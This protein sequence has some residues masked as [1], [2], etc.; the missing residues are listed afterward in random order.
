MHQAVD[1]RSG[2]HGILE[3]LL[4]LGEGQVTGQQHAAALVTL[5]Q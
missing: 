1:G 5:G 4:P 3:D 2:R